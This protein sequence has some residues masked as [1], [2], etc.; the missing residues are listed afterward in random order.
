MELDWSLVGLWI[1]QLFAV[2]EPIRIDRPPENSSVSLSLSI[3][4]DT[5]DMCHETA[6]DGRFSSCSGQ[7][8]VVGTL[9]CGCQHPGFLRTQGIPI[10]R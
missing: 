2:K 5:M 10:R 6:L 1:I 4:Q 3:I 8:I 9:S 7:S